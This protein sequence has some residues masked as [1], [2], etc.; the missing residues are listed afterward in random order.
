MIP[1]PGMRGQGAIGLVLSA[2]VATGCAPPEGISSTERPI[3]NGTPVTG[4]ASVVALMYETPFCTG[5]LVSPRHVLTAGHC[6]VGLKPG[7]FDVFFGDDA[8]SDGIRIGALDV[9]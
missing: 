7:M 5:V 3:V 9:Q 6:G 2:T 8:A 4:S 1:S